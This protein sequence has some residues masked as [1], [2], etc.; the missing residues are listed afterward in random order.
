MLRSSRVARLLL[1][2]VAL[3]ALGVCA[4]STVTV[5]GCCSID[6]ERF[7]A[8]AAAN[9]HRQV[10]AAWLALAAFAVSLGAFVGA[11]R[12]GRHRGAPPDRGELTER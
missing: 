2:V 7:P 5:L 12:V 9:R 10:Q 6:P 8:Q 1:G 3:L 11:V 4:G